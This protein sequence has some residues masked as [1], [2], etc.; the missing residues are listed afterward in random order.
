ML[1]SAC[2]HSLRAAFCILT[3]A[4]QLS[5]C[6]PSANDAAVEAPKS[7]FRLHRITIEE[8]RG[9]RL[10]WIGSGRKARGDL[11]ALRV[12]DVVLTRK[13]QR[14]REPTYTIRAPRGRLQLDAGRA[15]L[16]RPNIDQAAGGMLQARSAR[17]REARAEVAC[18]GPLHF[19][20]DGLRIDAASGRVDLR[21]NALHVH[22]PVRGRFEPGRIPADATP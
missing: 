9:D 21:Q 2:G 18:R 4:I 16:Q 3:L 14:P 12:E 22:G 1:S 8:R 15:R 11:S 7:Q 19:E 10:L 6:S 20:S 17:Y 13:P 5:A